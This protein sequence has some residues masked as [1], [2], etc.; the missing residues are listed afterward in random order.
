MGPA[1]CNKCRL[2][3][4]HCFPPP[5]RGRLPCVPRHPASPPPPVAAGRRLSSF[6]GCSRV[7]PGACSSTNSSRTLLGRRAHMPHVASLLRP[8]AAGPGPSSQPGGEGDT[9]FKHYMSFD[10][11]DGLAHCTPATPRRTPP[12]QAGTTP[13]A[14][15]RACLRPEARQ[16]ADDAPPRALQGPSPNHQQ[17]TTTLHTGGAICRPPCRW[18][19]MGI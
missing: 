18:D 17:H 15:A 8:P 14:T 9:L 10:D 11:A 6:A 12:P 2:V 5:N 7:H 13:R 19:H 4:D 16:D 1:T 3:V